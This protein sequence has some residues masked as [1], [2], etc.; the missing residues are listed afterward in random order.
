MIEFLVV[1]VINCGL[2]LI[3]FFVLDVVSCDCLFNGVV[4][5]INVE[6]VFFLFNGGELVVLVQ[7]GYE[8]VLQVIV[9]VLV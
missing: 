8:G 1:L 6:W 2:L 7:C 3:K 5:G 4:E 9:G